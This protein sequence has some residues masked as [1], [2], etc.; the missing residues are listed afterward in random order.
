MASERKGLRGGCGRNNNELLWDVSWVAL[1]LLVNRCVTML[2]TDCCFLLWTV[3]KQVSS[4]EVNKSCRWISGPDGHYTHTEVLHFN[5]TLVAV[6]QKN[7]LLWAEQDFK[8]VKEKRSVHISHLITNKHYKM[9]QIMKD[10]E[11]VIKISNKISK[12]NQICN[13]MS[14]NM[15]WPL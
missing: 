5:D 10:S 14:L 8:R 1:K 4:C 12:T 9:F 3:V 15:I 7:V 2:M 13:K 6:L 11:L